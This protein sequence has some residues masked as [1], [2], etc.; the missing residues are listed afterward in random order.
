MIKPAIAQL[1]EGRPLTEDQAYQVMGQV[2]AGQ[3]TPAQTAALLVALRIKGE[4]AEELLGLVRA[5]RDNALTVEGATDAIDT[6]GTGGDASGTYNISTASAIVAAAAGVKVAKHGN[7][8]A[9]SKCGSADVLEA[10]GVRIALTPAQARRCLE[11]AGIVFL[12]AQVYHPA[13]KHVAPVRAEIGVRTAFNVLGPLANPARVRRQVVGVAAA[14]IAPK[15]AFILQ[16]LGAQHALVVHGED[17]LDEITL[18]GPTQVHEV[19]GGQTLAYT[20]TPE[21]LGLPRAERSALAGGGREENAAIL[22]DLFNGAR[23]PKRDALLANA[24]AALVVGGKAPDLKAGV[25]L[26]ASVI[27]SGAARR[28]LDEWVRVTQELGTD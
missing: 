19:L 23:G 18:A 11:E 7:R 13:M 5:M 4:T 15:M 22:R 16:R 6:C 14:E 28:K 8:S 1:V 17:G 20:V 9:S 2:M 12:F 21:E 27:D 24:A 26:A 10:L 25:G 3:A